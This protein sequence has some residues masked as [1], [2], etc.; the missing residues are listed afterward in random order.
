MFTAQRY[1]WLKFTQSLLYVYRTTVSL[2]KVY[3]VFTLCLP[4]WL[5]SLQSVY[6]IVTVLNKLNY[7]SLSIQSR[8]FH[9]CPVN[10]VKNLLRLR[11]RGSCWLSRSVSASES[12][13]DA[14]RCGPYA[15][16]AA[17][18]FD[19]VR[20]LCSP[21]LRAWKYDIRLRNQAYLWTGIYDRKHE[22]N[23]QLE[24]ES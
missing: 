5:K 2:I 3:S 17:E 24:R 7:C 19:E 23:V 22:K 15:R 16:T 8:C 9:L 18:V 13:S 20:W 11:I 10:C 14:L 4:S 21:S 12:P 1:V 6:W